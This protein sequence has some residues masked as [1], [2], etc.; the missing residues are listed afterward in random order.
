MYTQ[1]ADGSRTVND[2]EL[3]QKLRETYEPDTATDEEL[4]AKIAHAWSRSVELHA[5]SQELASVTTAL[6]SMSLGHTPEVA[7]RAQ[8]TTDLVFDAL[9]LQSSDVQAE[10]SVDSVM[11]RAKELG[12]EQFFKISES[13]YGMQI[14]S[15]YANAFQRTMYVNLCR[16]IGEA[17]VQ[18]SLVYA[19]TENDAFGAIGSKGKFA[20]VGPS[21]EADA[22]ESFVYDTIGG[23]DV[24]SES[25]GVKPGRGKVIIS[26]VTGKPKTGVIPDS[27]YIYMFSG[28]PI[29]S[30]DA[31]T[32][33]R[34]SVQVAAAMFEF[35]S[36]Y[37]HR[38][39][40][41]RLKWT[42]IIPVATDSIDAPLPYL[43]PRWW[44]D[45]IN[46]QSSERSAARKMSDGELRNAA[47]R[48]SRPGANVKSARAQATRNAIAEELKSRLPVE[49]R[50][51]FKTDP[52]KTPQDTLTEKAASSIVNLW[53]RWNIFAR[54]SR[55]LG[56]KEVLKSNQKM[57]SAQL[58][59][60]ASTQLLLNRIQ[61]MLKQLHDWNVSPQDAAL[62]GS[63]LEAGA[64]VRFRDRNEFEKALGR[65]DTAKYYDH[66]VEWNQLMVEMGKEMVSLGLI[67]SEQFEM[68][69]NHY[70]P[71]RFAEV[72][73]TLGGKDWV[74]RDS[75]AEGG[76]ASSAELPR[77]IGASGDAMRRIFDIRYVMPLS[78]V[79]V[80]KRLETFRILNRL[81]AEGHVVSP[82][83]YERMGVVERQQYT[84]V[85]DRGLV[86][87]G[88]G[89]LVPKLTKEE[90][91]MLNEGKLS[92]ADADKILEERKNTKLEAAVIQTFIDDEIELRSGGKATM[93][94]AMKKLLNTLQNG[95]ITWHAS[96]EIAFLLE[97][98]DITA[99][100]SGGAL[101]SMTD[102]LQQVTL[103]WRQL[104]TVQN[105]KHWVLQ[106]TTNLSTNSM[107]GKVPMS[108]MFES[109]LTGEGVYAD[110]AW[111]AAEWYAA[112]KANLPKSQWSEGALN[113]DSTVLSI[114]GATLAHMINDP[115]NGADV[116]ASMFYGADGNPMF[117][118]SGQ[119]SAESD[120][121]LVAQAAYRAGRGWGSFSSRVSKLSSDP[122][123]AVRAEAVRA[124]LGVYNL[125]EVWW[126]HAAIIEAKRIGM[127]HEDAVRWASEGTG[128]FSDRNTTL[129]RMT[130]QFQTGATRLREEGYAKLGYARAGKGKGLDQNWRLIGR[131][132]V[133]MGAASPFW[134][135]RA[136]MYPTM[137]RHTMSW[138]GIAHTALALAMI[139]LVS[140]AFGGDD[141]DLREAA[142][143]SDVLKGTE[144]DPVTLDILRRRHGDAPLPSFGGSSSGK[145]TLAVRDWVEYLQGFGKNFVHAASLGSIGT[146]SQAGEMLSMSRGPTVGGQST[147]IDWKDYVPGVDFVNE[148]SASLDE[149]NDF[150]VAEPDPRN[151]FGMFS[152]AATATFLD[153]MKLLQGEKGKSKAQVIAEVAQGVAAEMSAPLGGTSVF[154]PGFS[155]EMKV[156][157][158]ESAFGS[159]TFSEMLAGLPSS[160]MKPTFAEM[161]SAITSRTLLPT[162]R[163][164]SA[165]RAPKTDGVGRVPLLGNP[166]YP[167]SESGE[168]ARADIRNR[169]IEQTIL[170]LLSR[171]YKESLD[172]ATLPYASRLDAYLNLSRDVIEDANGHLDIRQNPSTELGKWLASKGDTPEMRKLWVAETVNA[173]QSRREVL[174]TLLSSE[175]GLIYRKDVD[176]ALH[177]RIVRAAWRGAGDNVQLMRF[178]Y[179]QMKNT[180]GNEGILARIWISSGI[181]NMKSAKGADLE[182]LRLGNAWVA[183][184]TNGASV[185]LDVSFEDQTKVFGPA[186][187][188]MAP[189]TAVQSLP[190]KGAAAQA[191]RFMK[192]IR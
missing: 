81:V 131:Q 161:A 91:A 43:S 115:V 30:R 189:S 14:D 15:G 83:D 157:L 190:M 54:G 90:E 41:G 109:I 59:S 148:V 79:R 143:G 167:A 122:N 7:F 86:R 151:G 176:P 44:V 72:A 55:G 173:L 5:K 139:R 179:E 168:E 57:M 97:R 66:L 128:D 80:A 33:G 75:R 71:A 68:M 136:A 106:F 181:P 125:H 165:S 27:K 158:E 118:G 65:P 3:D 84:R 160:R 94:P 159:R 121:N 6:M 45:R 192:F 96:R 153:A 187:Y 40:S 22:D 74:L 9:E 77:D 182:A 2:L 105:P 73:E 4:E 35:A 50:H 46:L 82:E 36:G 126:K 140:Q 112:K 62:L 101:E 23:V 42:K 47:W 124:L 100:R 146:H 163:V 53:Q 156:A 169:Q 116:L 164:S 166:I 95:H 113:F 183:E 134:M 19:K 18:G 28:I 129:L 31:K 175:T 132:M 32:I 85:A 133:Q 144:L 107:T 39:L 70:L 34:W 60:A 141:E 120:L 137:A 16:A 61:T 174:D 188:D 29:T 142:A 127:K 186:M 172:M 138:R 12:I 99:Y 178:L 104:R 98:N 88:E 154:G 58:E 17:N 171:T 150:M 177:D 89:V 135:Y 87:T 147:I 93:T 92:R 145:A 184:R 103:M 185:D 117:R 24:E 10:S 180:S 25:S 56:T 1:N 21:G 78:A 155:R 52:K 119:S 123:P 49:Y 76:T 114:G 63:M 108:D 69:R 11:S 110:A 162:S 13:P 37:H 67:S 38:V 20:Y 152:M 26:K 111:E 170:N 48:W 51:Y 130:T 191:A 8:R 102:A 149:T 64:V